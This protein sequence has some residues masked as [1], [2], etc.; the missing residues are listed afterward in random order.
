MNGGAI[1][2]KAMVQ[3]RICKE[4]FDRLD[5]ANVEGRDFVKPSERMY[6]H[7]KCYDEYQASRLDVHANMT[8]ELWFTAT[9][10]FLRKDLKYSFNYVKVRKQWEG[11]LKK[12]MTAKGIYFTLKYFYEIKRGD[13]TKS[14]NGIGIVPHTYEDSCSYWYERE[15]RDKGICAAIEKQI[16]EAANQNIVKVKLN[17]NKRMTKCAADVLAAIESMEMEEKE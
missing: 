8:D 9:W 15:E 16:L 6:Y 3:C 13:V 17:K 14:E 2:A 7:K 4:K 12:K 1:M 5:P 10:D 11:F